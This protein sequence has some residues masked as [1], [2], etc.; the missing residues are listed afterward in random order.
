MKE[1]VA[2]YNV[3][4]IVCSSVWSPLPKSP[5]WWAA[6]KRDEQG[7]LDALGV[8]GERC[9]CI[10]T[11]REPNAPFRVFGSDMMQDFDVPFYSFTKAVKAYWGLKGH[12]DDIYISGVSPKVEKH[13]RLA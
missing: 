11:P 8:S 2:E 5:L 7:Y 9:G 4:C 6:K 13:L 1:Q 12:V 3:Q 10:K